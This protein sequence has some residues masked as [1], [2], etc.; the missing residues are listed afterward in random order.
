MIPV[1][2]VLLLLLVAILGAFAV[3]R[4]MGIQWGRRLG[5]TESKIRLRQESLE[6]GQCK[7]C[8]Q[9]CR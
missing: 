5:E 7:I 4:R 6:A 9:T 1:S 3:G 8:D 2:W